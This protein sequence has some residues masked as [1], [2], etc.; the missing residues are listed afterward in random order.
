MH[1]GEDGGD[2]VVEAETAVVGVTDGVAGIFGSWDRFLEGAVDVGVYPEGPESVVQV[3]DYEFGERF[4]V[5]EGLGWKDFGGR[6]G[7]RCCWV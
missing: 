3:E 5:G 1:G 4:A 6:E 2:F 7:D